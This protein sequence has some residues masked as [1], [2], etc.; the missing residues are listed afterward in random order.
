MLKVATTFKPPEN[1]KVDID[2]NIFTLILR[3]GIYGT[4]R[5]ASGNFKTQIIGSE[6]HELS[7]NISNYNIEQFSMNRD[8]VDYKKQ[9]HNILKEGKC[10]KMISFNKEDVGGKSFV[11]RILDFTVRNEVVE[12][13]LYGSFDKAMFKLQEKAGSGVDVL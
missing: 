5:V 12:D 4:L 13:D 2:G 10:G 7:C 11:A 8:T 3:E 9:A 1:F 6:E